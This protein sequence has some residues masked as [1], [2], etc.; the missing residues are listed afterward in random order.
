MMGD[1]LTTLLRTFQPSQCIQITSQCIVE[2]SA[3]MMLT[4][5]RLPYN[6]CTSYARVGQLNVGLARLCRLLKHCTSKYSSFFIFLKRT[7]VFLRVFTLIIY[8][9]VRMLKTVYVL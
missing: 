1:W 5:I 9:D 4:P 2:K 8:S 7:V 6:N 3:K